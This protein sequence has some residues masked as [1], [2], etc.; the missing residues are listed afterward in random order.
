M[1]ARPIA[2]DAAAPTPWQ[3]R[4]SSSMSIEP[5]AAHSAEAATKIASED[6]STGRRPNRSDSGP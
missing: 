5:A 3:N 1:Q 6:T 2:M 4:P